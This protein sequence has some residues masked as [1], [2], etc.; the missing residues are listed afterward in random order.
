MAD[1]KYKIVLEMSDGSKQ[2]AQFTIPV[3]TVWHYGTIVTGEGNE[4]LIPVAGAKSGD[5]YLNTD[6][7]AL[8]VA[9]TS[10]DKWNHIMTLGGG[11]SDAAM[12]A[13]V[14]DIDTLIGGDA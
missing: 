12:T 14:N 5:F 8:Y 4:I 9:T 10:G 11:G 7:G 2:E 1:K 13:F 6:T 3:G